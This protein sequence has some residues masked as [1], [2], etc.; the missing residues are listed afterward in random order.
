MVDEVS[1]C[2]CPVSIK[3]HIYE[4]KK[5]KKKSFGNTGMP[6]AMQME[7]IEKR[8]EWAVHWYTVVRLATDR[9]PAHAAAG[10]LTCRKSAAQPGP[11]SEAWECRVGGWG[12]QL[13]VLTGT[14]GTWRWELDVYPL[15]ARVRL[16]PEA[17]LVI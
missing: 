4:K 6:L 17:A 8:K 3:A 16:H 10:L 15:L 5:T 11:P 12:G 13:A 14:G 2:L 7:L 1:L 9:D